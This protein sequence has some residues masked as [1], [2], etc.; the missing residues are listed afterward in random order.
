VSRAGAAIT[1]LRGSAASTMRNYVGVAR[2]FL[3]WWETVAGGRVV[4]GLDEAVVIEFVLSKP[5]AACSA[6]ALRADDQ[7]GPIGVV[8]DSPRDAAQ[9][10]VR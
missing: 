7:Y 10:H 2:V 5:S 4:A 8:D 6:G 3:S 9:Q 1:T